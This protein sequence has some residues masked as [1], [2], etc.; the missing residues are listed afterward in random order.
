MEIISKSKEER[1]I[2][3][4]PPNFISEGSLFGGM[5]KLR[6]AIEAVVFFLGIAVPVLKIAAFSFTI[7]IIILCL[8]A[9]PAGIFALI[10]VGGESLTA[11]LMN[12][13]HFLRTRRIVSAETTC[14]SDEKRTD[15]HLFPDIG[16]LPEEFDEEEKVSVRKKRKKKQPAEADF[17]PVEKIENG[18]CYLK[19][20]RYIKIMEIEPINFLLRSAREQRN[21]IYSYMSYLKISP[22]KMQIKVISKKADLGSHLQK[23]Q[24]DI[25]QEKNEKC[26]ILLMDY[27]NLIRRIGLKEAVTRRF[28]MVLEYEPMP[29]GSK[30]N[31]EKEAIAQLHIAEQ[32]ARTYLRQ[33]GNEVIEQEKPEEFMAELFY[34]LLNRKKSNSVGFVE[35]AAEAV[36]EYFLAVDKTDKIEI[37]ISSLVMP[38]EIK[39]QKGSYIEID[40]LYYAYFMIPSDGYKSQV[41]AGWLSLLVN[42]GEGIDVDIFL[43]KEPKDKA[44]FRLGQQIRINRSK[45]KETSDTNTDFD[46]ID[47]AIRSGY[48]LKEGLANNQDFY[49]MNILIT[50]TADSVEELEWRS[51]EMKKLMV[52]QDLQ[53]KPCYFRQE[54]AFLSTLP[55]NK[56]EK[57]LYA[58]SKRNVLTSGVSG[59]YPYVSFE[60]SDDNGILLGV[61]RYN[62]SLIIVDIFNSKIYKNAN[63]AILGTSGAG[64]T[65]TLQLMAM[66]LREKNVQVFIL[67]PLKGHEFRRACHNIDGEFIQISPASHHC[68][69]IMEIRKTDQKANICLDG[70][71]RAERSELAAKIQRLHIFFSLLIPDMSHEERQL[72]DEA[73]IKTYALKGI[74]HQNA[75]LYQQDGSYKPMPVLGDVYAVLMENPET[76]RM[77]NILNRLV[78][79]SASTFNQQTNVRLDNKY[80]VLDISELTGDLL[81]VGMFLA[82]DYVWDKAK[83]DRTVEKA[84]F[85]D[86]VWQLI[87]A[88]SNRLAAEFVLEIFKIIRGYGGA[89]ICAT[90]DINDFLAL[91]DGKYGKGI[92][93]N[94]KTKIVLNL[95][96]E[97]AQRVQEILNL[98]DTEVMNITHFARG[99]G[100]I[101]TNNNNV[102]VEFKASALETEMITT[103]RQQL[104]ELLK[105]REMKQ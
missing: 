2:Y 55:L 84:I 37:P 51:N 16:D 67:A 46:E 64:K 24:N 104:Q 41:A 89:A 36:D 52:S 6:N 70:D 95:E 92:L 88:S 22:V 11:F 12:F 27:Y 102:T 48:Y 71:Q 10:G 20:K 83:E 99:N 7:K 35:N 56:M 53:M 77:A 19:D 26:K 32:T 100:L 101:L 65:F 57:G 14:V 28:F 61:N 25:A 59:C 58:L 30:K 66:R 91:D 13:F 5:L 23:I 85:I 69:N 76:K 1:D 103:D 31:E 68:I 17:F 87:G 60:M 4:I 82:L 74:T 93:N 3:L 34:I 54:Q 18:I 43:N 8:T 105:R 78:H 94:S 47:S 97:E 39:F 81:T 21:I 45:M 90:Q 50:I 75:S 44:Q 63:M 9:L 42:A 38:K 80:I 33:C 79:G 49:Y 98:S 86:E 73:L 62:N 29:G 96:D 72:L 15:K 40:G